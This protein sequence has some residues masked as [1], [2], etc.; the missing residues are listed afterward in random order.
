MT[1]IRDIEQR[2]P[3]DAARAFGLLQRS[4]AL[5]CALVVLEDEEEI[6]PEAKD[7]ALEIL[8]VMHEEVDEEFVRARRDLGIPDPTA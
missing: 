6:D 1:E 3:G 2:R 5:M 4:S 7:E 8:E